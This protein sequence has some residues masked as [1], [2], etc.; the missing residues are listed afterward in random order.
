M[1]GL[2][3]W[4]EALTEDMSEEILRHICSSHRNA[5]RSCKGGRGWSLQ[6]LK[7]EERIKLVEESGILKKYLPRLMDSHYRGVAVTDQL[8]W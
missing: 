2:S 8:A 7:R 6:P 1:H 5:C 3:R 4:F